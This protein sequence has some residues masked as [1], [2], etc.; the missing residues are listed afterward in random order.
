MF[1]I[2]SLVLLAVGLANGFYMSEVDFITI[3]GE[4]VEWP[5]GEKPAFAFILPF[6]Y[7]V[8]YWLVGAGVHFVLVW[9]WRKLLKIKSVGETSQRSL[10]A[11]I[12]FCLITSTGCISSKLAQDRMVI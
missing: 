1:V 11:V 5:T 10:L 3:D 2:I 6:L 8:C 7:A 9:G 4:P 12:G